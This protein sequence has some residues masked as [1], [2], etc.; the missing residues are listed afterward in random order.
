MSIPRILLLGM[1]FVISLCLA[2]IAGGLSIKWWIFVFFLILAFIAG[3][4]IF[5]T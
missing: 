5:A 2:F 1:T 3:Y 4:S